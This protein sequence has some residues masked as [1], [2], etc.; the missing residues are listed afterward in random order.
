M[1]RVRDVLQAARR[2]AADLAFAAFDF[3]PHAVVDV[4]EWRFD[5]SDH[6][7]T[8][9]VVLRNSVFPEQP[10]VATTFVVHFK[11]RTATVEEASI[12]ARHLAAS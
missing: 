8:R 5:T 9:T 6:T 1:Q 4:G 3:Q 12:L 7:W 11:D 10:G 2:R